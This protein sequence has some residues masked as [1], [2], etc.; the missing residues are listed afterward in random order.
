MAMHR[1]VGDHFYIE[2]TGEFAPGIECIV[3][4]MT[5]GRITKAKAAVPDPRLASRGFLIEGEDYVIVEW[6]W[7][8]N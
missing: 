3:L 7:S 8:E 2:A 1:Q 5:D 6:N 4:E